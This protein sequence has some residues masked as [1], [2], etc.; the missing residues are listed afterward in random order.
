MYAGIFQNRLLHHRQQ[1]TGR[2]DEGQAT[3]CP[4]QR[5]IE[6]VFLQH[7]F[8]SLLQTISGRFGAEAE[9]EINHD[10]T[11]NDVVRTSTCMYV[12]LFG[13]K[14]FERSF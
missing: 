8:E 3:Q 4:F 5:V 2:G 7:G 10:F 1:I 11:G 6:L 9:I 12:A 14:P 13:K